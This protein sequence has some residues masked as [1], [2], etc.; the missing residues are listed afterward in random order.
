MTNREALLEA[1]LGYAARGW[2][3]LPLHYPTG[4]GCSC[5]VERGGVDARCAHEGKHPA[6]KGGVASATVDPEK[7][8]RWWARRPWNVGIATGAGVR[9]GASLVVVDVDPRHAGDIGL[10]ELEAA[11]ERL[12][13]SVEACTGSGGR[14]LFYRYDPAGG[15]VPCSVAKLG[16]G[17]DVRGDGGLVVAPPSVHP[18]G[19]T[20]GWELSSDPAELDVVEA[21]TWLLT[22]CRGASRVGVREGASARRSGE[23]SSGE[24]IPDGS[25]GD[26]LYR[27]ACGWRA[28]GLDESEVLGALHEVNAARCAPPCDERRVA[29]IAASACKHPAGLSPSYA[30]QRDAGERSRA[31]A[32]RKG[33]RVGGLD[34]V[35]PVPDDPEAAA[36]GS[37]RDALAEV[38]DEQPV[39]EHPASGEHPRAPGGGPGEGRALTPKAVAARAF[40]EELLGDL[41][42]DGDDWQRNLTRGRKGAIESTLGNVFLILRNDRRVLRQRPRF[43]ELTLYAEVGEQ[44]VHDT[45]LTAIRAKVERF[46]SLSPAKDLAADALRLV[47][48]CDA[49]NPVTEY[50]SALRW[51]GVS[52]LDRIASEWFGADANEP[53]YRRFVL[54]FFLGAVGRAFDPGCNHASVLVLVGAQGVGK[55]RFFRELAGLFFN[56]SRIEVGEKDGAIKTHS[57]WIHEFPEVESLTLFRE[58]SSVKAF[59]T[60]E[61]DLFRPPYGRT[62][63]NVPRSSIFVATTNQRDFLRDESGTGSRRWH[64]IFVRT[65][66]PC[67]L[68]R[69]LRDQLWA[70]AV[71]RW[72]AGEASR[73]TFEE[74]Q[75]R[76]VLAR[77]FQQ[78]D[79]W[80]NAVARW[81]ATAPEVAWFSSLGRHG[82]SSLDL[83]TGAL[84]HRRGDVGPGESRRLGG[85]M[86]RLG[87]EHTKQRFLIGTGASRRLGSPE[88][89]YL[90][91]KGWTRTDG[92]PAP[93]EADDTDVDHPAA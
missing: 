16:A 38:L 54:C 72:R 45:A 63:V 22:L 55:S 46:W 41:V 33:V 85:I 43:N 91:P 57:A 27:L 64:P 83:H 5:V 6:V 66:I 67:E 73:L 31:L 32:E 26:T 28:M 30:A 87:W 48:E 71:V 79:E 47:A 35:G 84:G 40:L 44:I 39:D 62:T 17:V 81:V 80:E 3:V 15:R 23:Y 21:P 60:F 42:L 92:A 75:R 29:A 51:D 76:E 56:E 82:V 36:A 74:E 77:E 18:S 53:L 34:D 24:A 1:A 93:G 8:R 10:D 2:R 25:R 59:L 37:H 90:A 4:D 13:P 61:R 78:I 69:E 88:N 19:R 86:A 89:G 68:V 52:R 49:Y 11:H 65:R 58:A 50:L 14:H 70:E 7:I 9:E 12:P 20:Y